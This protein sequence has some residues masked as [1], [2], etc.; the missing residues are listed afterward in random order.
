MVQQEC[1]VKWCDRN[2]AW[3][4]AAGNPVVRMDMA[5]NGHRGNQ[6]AQEEYS[7]DIKKF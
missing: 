6:T 3:N 2:M 4:G 7:L 1:G 5:W